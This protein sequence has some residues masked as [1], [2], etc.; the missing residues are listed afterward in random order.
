MGGGLNLEVRLK[1]REGGSLREEKERRPLFFYLLFYPDLFKPGGG[2]SLW[3]VPYKKK[4]GP[5]G[6]VKEKKRKARAFLP[7]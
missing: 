1:K 2:T 7:P 4:R 5:W 3:L 6:G